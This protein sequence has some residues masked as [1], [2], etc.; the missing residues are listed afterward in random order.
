MTV[1]DIKEDLIDSST[2]KMSNYKAMKTPIES[3]ATLCMMQ[4]NIYF[5]G[6]VSTS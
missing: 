4:L 5:I 1:A 2:Y 3:N 6:S